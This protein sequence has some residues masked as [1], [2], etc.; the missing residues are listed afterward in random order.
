MTDVLYSGSA[1][2]LGNTREARPWDDTTFTCVASL[3]K[4]VTATS[5]MQLVERGSVNLDSDVRDLAPRLRELQILKGFDGDK[6]PVL[7]NYDTP[8]TP[9]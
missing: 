9:R 7:E 4:V 8:I 3:T 6:K 2:R 5:I 1:G